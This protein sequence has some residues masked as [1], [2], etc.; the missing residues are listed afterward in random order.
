MLP[1]AQLCFGG[2]VLHGP[3]GFPALLRSNPELRSSDTHCP[4]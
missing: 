4:D 3:C 1:A 2:R